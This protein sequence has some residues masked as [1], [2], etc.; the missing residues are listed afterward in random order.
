MM[1]VH[2]AVASNTAFCSSW[3][4]TANRRA[5]SERPF[6]VRIGRFHAERGPE[7]LGPARRAPRP[8]AV[9]RLRSAYD[10]DLII[11]GAGVGGH[12]AAL[13][14]RSKGLKTAVLTGGDAGGTCVNRGC[15]PSKALLAAAGKLRELK[16]VE[17]LQAMGIAVQGQVAYDRQAVSNHANSLASRVRGNLVQSLRGLGVDVLDARGVLLEPQ[18]VELRK[19]GE[20]TGDR[21]ITAR[22]V[23]IATGSVPAV[24]PGIQIDGKTVFTSDDAL[25]LEWIP[26]W[27]AI[28]GSGY[29]GLEFSDVYTALGSEVTFIE[30]A[31]KLMPSF[32]VEISRLAERLLISPRPIDAYTGVFAAKVVPGMPGKTPVR[33]E[34]VDAETR[35]PVEVLET[36]AALVATGRRPFTEG[37]GIEKLGVQLDRGFVPVDD[38][39]QVLDQKGTPIEHLFCI[40][41]ANGKL[42]LAHAASAQGISVVE[43]IA[44][45]QSY[46]LRMECIPAACFTH[47]EISM[48][49]LTEQQARDK[50][51]REQ[52]ELGR[53]V[54]HFRANSKALAENHAEGIAKVLFR[55]DTGELLGMHIIG[56]HAA[57]LIHEAAN[58]MNAGVP[59]HKLAFS[60]HTHPTLSEICD[61]AFKAAAGM[62]AH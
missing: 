57:D 18:K 51:E 28:I 4:T 3:I 15:V 52:F 24:P 46:F 37:L 61:E 17:R 48:V 29:I 47:P 20:Q 45:N 14:A 54:G 22:D 39:M 35:A 5:S 16:S 32:D 59:I 34:L 43:N 6:G 56:M 26:D 21:R 10:Y 49:G 13:H 9:F 1:V 60:V 44:G 62:A 25:K 53:A 36:D 12:G 19:P 55:K 41:D 42:M 38:R 2:S 23:I 33:I 31:P 11:I 8:K 30:A 58:A 27:I 40:G 50:A 7:W